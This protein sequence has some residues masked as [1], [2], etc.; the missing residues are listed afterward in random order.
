MQQ[1]AP[2][3]IQSSEAEI[4]AKVKEM[5]ETLKSQV[6]VEIL[7]LQKKQASTDAKLD[8]TNQQVSRV[9]TSMS[10]KFQQLS[11]QNADMEDRLLAA[12]A[13]TKPSPP[14]KAA[15]GDNAMGSEL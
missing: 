12:I 5:T 9:E 6:Q 8:E 14:R 7:A 1:V 2:D 3:R 15:K 4:L 13:G 11:Q 10:S